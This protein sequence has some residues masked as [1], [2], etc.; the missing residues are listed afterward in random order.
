MF[1]GSKYVGMTVHV[2]LPR[3]AFGFP[4]RT[5]AASKNNSA[6]IGQRQ[7]ARPVICEPMAPVQTLCA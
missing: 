3:H 7:P 5:A 4:A 2:C 6:S 1:A